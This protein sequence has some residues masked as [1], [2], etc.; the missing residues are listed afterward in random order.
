MY[1]RDF[2]EYVFLHVKITCLKQ[3]HEKSLL[4]SHIILQCIQGFSIIC[5]V[6]SFKT[7]KQKDISNTYQDIARQ[8]NKKTSV[9]K[10]LPV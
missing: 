3:E 1:V 2:T 10:I 6:Q 7:S 5:I 9:I 8:L 4:S